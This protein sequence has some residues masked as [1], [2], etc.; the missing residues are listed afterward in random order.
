[1]RPTAGRPDAILLLASSALMNGKD[2]KMADT[3]GRKDEKAM[4]LTALHSVALHCT[5]LPQTTVD[6]HV[7][8]D[9]VDETIT[10]R[11]EV[12]KYR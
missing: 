3:D 6:L 2:G 9:L 1:M 8:V 10:E 12:A 11:S 4:D 5:A 7:Q